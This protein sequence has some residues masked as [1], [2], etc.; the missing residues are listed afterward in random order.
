MRTIWRRDFSKAKFFFRFVALEQPDDELT[1]FYRV[2]KQY[3]LHLLQLRMSRVMVTGRMLSTT[4]DPRRDPPLV[5]KS[6]SM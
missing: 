2:T 3:L 6:R 1:M 4:T 5:S